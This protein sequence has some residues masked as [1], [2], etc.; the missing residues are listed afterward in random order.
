MFKLRL[1]LQFFLMTKTL[2]MQVLG[3][4]V[5]L[6]APK[7]RSMSFV[8][9]SSDLITQT[10]LQRTGKSRLM[11]HEQARDEVGLPLRIFLY[12][13]D[14]LAQ[15][16]SLTE[17]YVR[18]KLFFYDVREPG[19]RPRNRLRAVNIAPEGQTPEWRVAERELIRYLR[20][21]GIKIYQRTHGW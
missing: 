6:S 5:K 15:M 11:V 17:K 21:K 3:R 7:L 19:I 10:F 4:L 1:V 12:T 16:L 20:L 9:R 2:L 18:E 13:P 14:Q 8:P